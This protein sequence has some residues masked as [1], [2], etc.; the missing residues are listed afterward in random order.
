MHLLYHRLSENG[1]VFGTAFQ[2]GCELRRRMTPTHGAAR[3]TTS[4]EIL[5]R[6]VFRITL[7]TSGGAPV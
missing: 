2:D 1:S 4:L 5:L 6:N 3:P 7:P